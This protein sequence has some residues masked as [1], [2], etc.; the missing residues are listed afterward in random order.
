MKECLWTAESKTSERFLWFYVSCKYM[1]ELHE[2][3]EVKKLSNCIHCGEKI[4]LKI[5]YTGPISVLGN[6]EFK[7]L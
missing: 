1:K 5:E 6:H 4:N 2:V 7:I 3:I